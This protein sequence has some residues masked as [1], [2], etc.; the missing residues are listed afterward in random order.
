MRITI[1]YDNHAFND[2]LVPD[3]GF[4]ALIEARGRT[5]LFDTGAREQV[6][7]S[8]MKALGVSAGRIDEVFISHDHWDHTGGLPAI[9]QYKPARVYVPETISAVLSAPE[10]VCVS[11]CLEM[12]DNIYSTGTLENIEQ[13]L[14]IKQDGKVVVI[15]GCSHPGVEAILEAAS[16]FGPPRALVGGLHGFSNFP[17]LSSLDWICATHCTRYRREI[18]SRFPGTAVEGGAGRI[19]EI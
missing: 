1:L 8:N 7:L 3:W 17:A 12:H 2:K 9:L 15:A 14:C 4:A 18:M 11:G 13:S 6:L 5:I 19:I 16:R 10:T